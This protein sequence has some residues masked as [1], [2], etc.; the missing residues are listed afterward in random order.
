MHVYDTSP[1][2]EPVEGVIGM[3]DFTPVTAGSVRGIRVHIAPEFPLHAVM[4]AYSSKPLS[5]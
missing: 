4:H 5:Y 2:Y 1:E 3:L